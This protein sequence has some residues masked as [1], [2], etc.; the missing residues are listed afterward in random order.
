MQTQLDDTIV[1][2][3]LGHLAQGAEHILNVHQYSKNHSDL[4]QFSRQAHT[5]LMS[6][7]LAAQQFSDHEAYAHPFLIN[8]EQQLLCQNILLKY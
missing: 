7:C 1:P 4:A 3:A 5:F 8:L 6:I 2:L